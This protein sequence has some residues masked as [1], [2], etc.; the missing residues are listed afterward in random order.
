[1]LYF[2]TTH[3]CL[4]A[5]RFRHSWAIALS[6]LCIATQSVAEDNNFKVDVKSAFVWGND[7]RGGAVSSIVQDPLTG[8]PMLQ[9]NYGGIDVT[10]RMGFER[11][12]DGRAGEFLE[13]ATTVVND[14]SASVSVQ[15]G[16]ISVDGYASTPPILVSDKKGTS[17][18][19]REH[20]TNTVGVSTLACFRSGFLRSE[21][22]FSAGHLS[23]IVTVAPGTALTVSSLVKDPRNYS[24]RCSLN[25]CYPT[26]TVRYYLRIGGHDFVFVWPG[27]SVAYCGR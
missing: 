17:N 23:D 3:R 6:M 25:G 15:Y 20:Q 8:R 10:S 22:V 13:Y 1:V 14:T 21:K 12:G 7:T 24:V 5:V 11:V 19:K 4:T 2:D 9:L 26:G 16:G 27:S 18:T